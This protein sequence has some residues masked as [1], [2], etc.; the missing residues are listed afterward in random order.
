[1]ALRLDRARRFSHVSPQSF[2]IAWHVGWGSRSTPP[3]T[4][5]SVWQPGYRPPGTSRG[6]TG[7][8]SWAPAVA[9]RPDC[10]RLPTI[11][12]KGLSATFLRGARMTPPS[13]AV[14]HPSSGSGVSAALPATPS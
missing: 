10:R 4:W 11:R 13:I 12:L 3:E 8:A 5:C 9:G 2:P 6:V 1:M 7:D 14:T